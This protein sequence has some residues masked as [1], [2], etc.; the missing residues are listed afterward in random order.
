MHARSFFPLILL[1]GAVVTPSLGLIVPSPLRSS[2]VWCAQGVRRESCSY[3]SNIAYSRNP[4]WTG[5][6]TASSADSNFASSENVNDMKISASSTEQKQKPP[7]PVVLWKFT[8]PHTIIG[9]ALAIPALHILAAPTIGAAF[10]GKALSA[11]AYAMIPALLMNL[12]ITG[13]NQITDVEID[14]INKPNLPIAAGI[15]SMKTATITVIVSLF[16]SLYLG[17]ANP[18]FATEGLNA[19]LWLSGIMGTLYSLP[20][21]RL[22]R[23]PVMAAVCIVAVRGAVIN[24][25]FFA[26]SFAAA[27][28]GV[29]SGS[30]ILTCLR[31]NSACYLSSM[32]FGVFGLVIALMKDVPDVA[33]DEQANVRT[34]SVRVGQKA[35][36]TAMRRLLSGSFLAVGAAFLRSAFMAPTKYLVAGR[37]VTSVAAILAGWSTRREAQGV[38]PED[39]QQVYNYY[40][41][42]WK[43]FY[44]SY[45]VLPFAR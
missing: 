4:A 18:K 45:L 12:Y 20:P 44:L 26:H 37:I 7:F 23:F 36:Y 13:L 38:D 33:G 31:N 35:V 41:H 10:T 8:R 15:L 17:V 9:S 22:K 40:M 16:L 24:A 11:M 43:L 32:F 19:A 6:H 28:G 29:A 30:I 2:P 34:F 42:L 1:L 14:K 5:L 25:S 3:G 27:Y 39:S 21:F